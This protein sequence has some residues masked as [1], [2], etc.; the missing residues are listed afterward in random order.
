MAAKLVIKDKITSV[1]R[2]RSVMLFVNTNYWEMAGDRCSNR[3]CQTY[4][5]LRASSRPI[6]PDIVGHMHEVMNVVSSDLQARSQITLPC[7]NQG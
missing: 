1:A 5:S 2:E 6:T 4:R 7:D 3:K